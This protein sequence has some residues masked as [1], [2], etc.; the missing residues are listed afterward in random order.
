M[1]KERATRDLSVKIQPSLFEKLAQ[2]CKQNYRSV[3][4]VV[5]ELLSRY[6]SEPDLEKNV[7]VE[8]VIEGGD[9]HIF[10]IHVPSLEEVGYGKLDAEKFVQRVKELMTEKKRRT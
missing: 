4:D 2:K 3:S 5:R 8:K 7:Y 9:R 10:Y 6:V 1:D